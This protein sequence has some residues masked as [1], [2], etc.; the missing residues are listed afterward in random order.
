VPKELAMMLYRRFVELIDDK[1]QQKK[2][3]YE[4]IKPN[5]YEELEL[6]KQERNRLCANKFRI[7]KTNERFRRDEEDLSYSKEQD[8]MYGSFIRAQKKEQGQP[9]EDYTL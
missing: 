2:E 3:M 7:M 1:K 4:M 8:D 5:L 9:D 6:V